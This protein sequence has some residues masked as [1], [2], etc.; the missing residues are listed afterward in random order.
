MHWADYEIY[1]PGVVAPLHALPRAEARR[2]FDR[3]MAAKPGRLD[4]LGGLLQVNG[5]ALSGTDEGVQD[6]NDWFVANVEAD[7]ANPGRLVPAWYSIV[8]DVGLFLGEVIIERSPGLRWQFYTGAKKDVSSQR[9]VIMGFSRVSNPKYNVDIDGAV[10]RYAHRLVASRGSVATHG[11][12]TV[13]G[14]EIDVDAAAARD[15]D[16]QVEPDAFWQWVKAA[17]SKA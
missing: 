4:G 12:Q 15:R 5:V 9:H 14:V 6:L 11:T 3:L 17:G 13:R 16:R 10:A 8:N 2:A 1:D 7:P